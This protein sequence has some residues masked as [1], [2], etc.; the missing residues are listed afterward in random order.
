MFQKKRLKTRAAED[1]GARLEPSIPAPWEI[2]VPELNPVVPWELP[3]IPPLNLDLEEEK[4][5]RSRDQRRRSGD[6]TAKLALFNLCN[7][8]FHGIFYMNCEKCFTKN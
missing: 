3:P 7:S 6:Y 1:P 8:T 2:L 5:N 4:V